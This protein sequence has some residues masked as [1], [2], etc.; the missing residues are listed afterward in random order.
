MSP[1]QSKPQLSK[2]TIPR[3]TNGG[4]TPLSFGQQRM[5]FLQQP[6][7]MSP[8]YNT[9]RTWR[10][11]GA[12]NVEAL[13]KAVQTIITRHS[14]LRTVIQVVDG[15]ACQMTDDKFSFELP[16]VDLRGCSFEAPEIVCKERIQQEA[17]TP[18]DLSRGPLFRAKLWRLDDEDHVLLVNMH[19]I[20]TDGWSFGVLYREI[21]VLYQAFESEDASPLPDL[22]LQYGDYALWQHDFLQGIRMEKLLTYWRRQLADL[23]PLQLPTDRIRTTL[24]TFKGARQGFAFGSA[25]TAKLKHWSQQER[26]TL[27]T[28]LLTCYKVL[29]FRYSGQTDIAVGTM[30][31]NRTHKEV[32][33]LIGMFMNT[34]VL[35]S[36]LSDN[37]NFRELLQRVRNTCQGAYAHQELPFDRLIDEL[38]P[39]RKLDQS[40]LFQVAIIYHNTP[41]QTLALPGL[42][43]R[44][45]ELNDMG[46]YQ[47]GDDTSKFDL[48]LTL[49][50]SN[51]EIQGRV[52]YNTDLFDNATIARL[53]GHYETLLESIV[54][55][56]DQRISDVQILTDA[57]RRQLLVDWNDTRTNYPDDRC[58]HQ[59]FEQQ[60]EQIPGA[61]ALVYGDEQFTYRELNA[62]ANQLAYYLRKRGVGPE[63]LV[64][65]CMERSIE[66]IV[67]LLGILKAGGA[68]VP[69]DPAYPKERLA[70]IL[71]DTAV[72][73]LLTQQRLLEALPDCGAKVICLDSNWEII[74]REKTDNLVSVATAENLAYVIY[75]SGS[76]GKPKGVLVTHGNVVR[77][78][79]STRHWFNF[80]EN[81]VWTLF[82]SYAF[83]FSVWEIWGALL[84]GGRL[85]VVPFWISRSFEAFYNLICQEKVTVLNQTPSAFRQ[86]IRTEETIGVAPNLALRWVIFG[87]EA[88]DVQSLHPWFERH[89]E[90]APQLVNMYGITE[91]TVHVTYRPIQASD[92]ETASGSVIGIPI[93]DLQ[94]YI[95]DPQQQ[96]VPIGVPG[97]M[98]IGGAGV[99]QGYLNRPELT[100]ERFIPDPFTDKPGSYLYKSG[101]LARYLSNRDIEY[102]GRLD[103]QVKIRG[104]R[105]ELGEIESVLS[106]HPAVDETV[107]MLNENDPDDKRLVAYVVPDQRNT[108]TV[109]QLLNAKNKNTLLNR[110]LYEL[111]N[112]MVIVYLNQSETDFMYQEIFERRSYLKHGISLD[113]GD[114]IFD[115]GAN[116][117]LF[118]LQVGQ[119]CNNAKIYAFEPMP[120][121]SEILRL[122]TSLNKIDADVCDYGLGS[123]TGL[124]SFTFYPYVSI[125]SGL[126]ANTLEE[127]ETVK[128][129][130]L[131]QALKN[132]ELVISNEQIEELLQERLISEQFTCPIKTLSQVIHEKEIEKI[133]LLKVDVE[134]SELDVLKGI[135]EEDWPKI[136]QVVV[137]V[138]DTHDQLRQITDLFKGHGF[139]VKVEQDTELKKTNLYAIGPHK[140]RM[141]PDGVMYQAVRQVG[142]RWCS[143]E[144]LVNELR[145]LSKTKLPDYAVPSAFI[146]IETIPLTPNGK[147]DRRALPAPDVV[148]PDLQET[149]VAP[150]SQSE[151]LVAGIW[152]N[153]LRLERIGVYDSFFEL[154]G[155]SLLVIQIISR[156][157]EVFEVELPVSSLFEAP[158]VAGLTERI[159]AARRSDE[160]LKTPP[161]QAVS[162]DKDLLLSFA[163]ERLWFLH[164]LEPDSV[165]YSIPHSI[166]LK[167]V[168]R[169]DA[170][171][172]AYVELA[173]R[174]ETLRTTF[175]STDG[176]PV[177]RIAAEPRIPFDTVD[178]RHLPDVERK[179]E[180]KR[181]SEEDARKPFDL[182]QGPLFRIRVFQL[183]D[184]VH[185]LYSN[186][187]HIISDFW[188]FGV[189]AREVA[190]LYTAFIKDES[191]DLPE[192]PVQYADY[193]VWQRQWLQGEALE[194]Q[195]NYWQDKLGGELPVLDLPTDRPRPAVQTHRGAIESLVLPKE[196]TDAL[197]AMSRREGV[198]LFMTLLAA[199]KTLL[200][201]LTGQGEIIVGA[202]IA[203][204]NRTE[205]EG[206][207]GFFMNTIVM[208][209]DLS[210]HP[211]FRELLGRVKETALGAYAHQ[212]MPFERLVEE[213]SPERDLSRP[214][215]FQVLFN[216]MV[217]MGDKA[218]E[219]PGLGTEAVGG[220]DQES[221]FD[222]T[223]NVW[224]GE[225]GIELRS[226]YNTD[227]FDS[228]RMAQM[229]KQYQMLLESIVSH[230]DQ[231]IGELVLMCEKEREKVIN[232]GSGPKSKYPKDQGFQEVFARQVT[233]NSK[234]VA[235]VLEDQSLTYHELNTRANQLAHYLKRHGVG[236]E[237]RVGLCLNRSIEMI[238]AVL[239]IFKAGGAYV[240]MDPNY[241]QERLAFVAKDADLRVILTQEQFQ[242]HL[243]HL[244]GEHIHLDADWPVIGQ[245]KESNPVGQGS[246]ES[247]AYVLF[248]S[249][250]TGQPKGVEVEHRQVLNYV[251]GILEQLK[252]RAGASFA[253]VSPLT[254][255]L[256]N[257]MLYP[258]LAT[259]GTLHII[260][261]DRAMDSVA[262]GAYFQ[263]HQPD[264]LKI[265]PSHLASLLMGPA[266]AEVLSQKRLVVGGEACPWNLVEKVQTLK[267]GCRVINHYG[268]TETTVGVT[269]HRV[270][271][272][273][274]T[275][276][277]SPSVPIGR[278]LPN[279]HIYILDSHQNP[280]PLGVAG[281]V[282]VGGRGIAR[283]YAGAPDLTAEKFVPHHYSEKPGARLYKTGDR[284]KFQPDGTIEFLGRID[285][286]VKL[287][288][289]RIEL[290]EIETVLNQHKRVQAATVVLG[291]KEGR[292]K[293]LVAYVVPRQGQLS[294]SVLR[295]FLKQ[296]LPEYMVPTIFMMLEDLPLTPNG[297]VNRRALPAPDLERS[298]LETKLV[299]PR[300]QVEKVLAKIWNEVLGLERVG[301]HDNFFEL[302]GHSLMATRVVSRIQQEFQVDLKLIGFFK[303]PTIAELTKGIEGLLWIN[304]GRASDD[305]AEIQDREE[306]V[307]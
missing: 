57:E 116:I 232:M 126:F 213:L 41:D 209:T 39:E 180:V 224:E 196:L 77:L 200:Y 255:D 167:G 286:Q 173:R 32:E 302:G 252:L 174:H 155:H 259:G 3:Q 178:L 9:Y 11:R 140:R 70:F 45:F 168:L 96:P 195:L 164:H 89:P 278:P 289:F 220:L 242:E 129:F 64:G 243:S 157:R 142:Q 233:R 33:S 279:S 229:L 13:K 65:I 217:A 282:Y 97:E 287:R 102:L 194:A 177:L 298:R 145:Q 121:V 22:P 227:L 115:V 81:D 188:S 139:E 63:V 264:C 198:T 20:I 58:V 108:F 99:A 92:L 114:C 90:T 290:G 193:A 100:A 199:F 211:S 28:T 303:M 109:R 60:V 132:D 297:K 170:L 238:V 301:V 149:F 67:G 187:H 42:G 153:V 288:G 210:G 179:A 165:A 207:I 23:T 136:Q 101:D 305:E 161:L 48:I 299:A 36:D 212:D 201:R 122:N 181:L 8:L 133:D 222:M 95:L 138:H 87:G 270:E 56:P 277:H 186:M 263:H 85:V 112:G 156:I 54:A 176:N 202:P 273:D 274:R 189:M 124:A 192:L 237:V 104:F 235:V 53:I 240:P 131:D 197:R 94:L 110:L 144:R 17:K 40:P 78:F 151:E 256:G 257:T 182:R 83:D 247:L 175:H 205:L 103:H 52:V 43:V 47:L 183:E 184:E 267:P 134:K 130:L 236:P 265:V 276:I 61:V 86:L 249:G 71:Q 150:R 125:L 74:D 304:A 26:V 293:Q 27:F 117:G 281:E 29:L 6:A 203:G 251:D 44:P 225:G 25:L 244:G 93:P 123:E 239:G 82:H 24:S 283:G 158:T 152:S 80:D 230:P 280:V 68:Y 1:L 119:I 253:M 246:A 271:A 120:P 228:W 190:A 254:A 137:E 219:L 66:M 166:R 146:L 59:L 148:R 62:R 84:Y 292:E 294:P 185:V 105:I 214:P 258:A 46:P 14:V 2:H 30:K 15:N 50:K 98:C 172:K 79:T 4:V 234:A 306:G 231:R 191:A 300:T 21:S 216:H 31:H 160:G 206:L 204:R 88:L 248:T 37:P 55:D 34:L 7:P 162:L 113:E 10:V 169:K 307:V 75:T 35:R 226:I 272:T 284:A 107:V 118:T 76:T 262:L 218:A 18:F 266:P 295:Q 208:R 275:T 221:K 147:V 135:N 296:T 241:P 223:L 261:E 106:Q 69:L 72:P 141:S 163:Q 285:H 260:S 51:G 5:W 154:G 268:P 127:H 19:H 250:S 91:T 245:E 269:T 128:N 215:L 49:V 291:E 143:P 16:V 111:P 12:L 171:E 159:E 38:H 73:V